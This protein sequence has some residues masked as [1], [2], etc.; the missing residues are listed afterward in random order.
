MKEETALVISETK[1]V[2]LSTGSAWGSCREE[3]GERKREGSGLKKENKNE[4]R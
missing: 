1:D 4:R 2:I 3:E